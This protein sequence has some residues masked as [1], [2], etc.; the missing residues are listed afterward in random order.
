MVTLD[1][2]LNE[3]NVG[4]PGRWKHPRLLVLLSVL[5]LGLSINA[6]VNAGYLTGENDGS[7]PGSVGEWLAQQGVFSTD[8]ATAPGGGQSAWAAASRDL[9]RRK[10]CGR[11]QR[12]IE[13]SCGLKQRD[14]DAQG[15]RTCIAQELQYT[16]WSAYGCQ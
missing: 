4:A 8:G 3:G 10:V 16:M 5:A 6:V 13:T 1:E 11:M 14:R 2:S 15:I 12:I 7:R 9:D